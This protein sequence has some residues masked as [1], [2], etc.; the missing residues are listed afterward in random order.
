[1]LIR[2]Y[3]CRL[4]GPVFICGFCW[5]S[6]NCSPSVFWAPSLR[7]KWITLMFVYCEQTIITFIQQ[8]D[9][10]EFTLT[11]SNWYLLTLQQQRMFLLMMQLAQ[12]PNLLTAGTLPL[13]MI[14]FV[15]VR[16]VNQNCGAWLLKNFCF[17]QIVKTVYTAGM[18]LIE[19]TTMQWK[20]G[21]QNH[22]ILTQCLNDQTTL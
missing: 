5:W 13:N 10:L 6:D 8:T 9:D 12:N 7:F 20:K 22:V 2:K 21:I 18:F 15:S 17:F 14:T 16:L 11:Q 4:I 3:D 1:M 19:S